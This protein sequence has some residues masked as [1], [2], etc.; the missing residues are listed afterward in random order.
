MRKYHNPMNSKTVATKEEAKAVETPTPKP[1]AK[2]KTKAK[3][4]KDD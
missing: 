4:K 2:A 3:P 1:K